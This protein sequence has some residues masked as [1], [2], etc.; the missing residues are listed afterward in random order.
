MTDD[1][2]SK[3]VLKSMLDFD[4]DDFFGTGLTF[5]EFSLSHE[6]RRWHNNLSRIAD[7]SERRRRLKL[8]RRLCVVMDQVERGHGVYAMAIAESG[9]EAIFNGDW[10]ECRIVADMLRHDG[11]DAPDIA[12]Y[13]AA[14]APLREILLEA[15]DTA[16][17]AEGVERH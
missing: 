15:C 17:P 1:A 14:H 2:D 3:K 4:G 12:V 5:Q 7:R 6:Y 11:E 13:V 10:K 16:L 9:L 8:I